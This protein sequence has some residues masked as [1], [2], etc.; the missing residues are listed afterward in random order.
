[1]LATI[2]VFGSLAVAQHHQALPLWRGDVHRRRHQT[3]GIV[4]AA[5]RDHCGPGTRKGD[6]VSQIGNLLVILMCYTIFNKYIVGSAWTLHTL[7]S[8][9]VLLYMIPVAL[10]FVFDQFFALR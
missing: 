5:C 2:R 10:Y 6:Q 9:S 3:C 8:Y 7:M 4:A 1:M